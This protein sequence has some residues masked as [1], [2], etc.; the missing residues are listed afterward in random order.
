MGQKSNKRREM[1]NGTVCTVGKFGLN[2]TYSKQFTPIFV[3]IQYNIYV[4]QIYD[5]RTNLFLSFHLRRRYNI[6]QIKLIL[7]CIVHNFILSRINAQ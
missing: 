2:L 6:F 3:S 4:K 7:E 5:A 1:P